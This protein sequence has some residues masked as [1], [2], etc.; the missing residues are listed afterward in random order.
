MAR[1]RSAAAI[2][3]VVIGCASQPEDR[4]TASDLTFHQKPQITLDSPAPGSF[5]S[6]SADGTIEVSGKAKGRSLTINGNTVAVD[7]QGAFR[8]RIPAAP[9]INIVD[10]HL[11]SFWG[12]ELQRAFLYGNFAGAHAALQGGVMVRANALAFDDGDGKPDLNDLSSISL[13]MLKQLDVM[14]F[15]RQLPPFTYDFGAGSVDISVTGVQFA[16]DQTALKL[17]PK[18]VGARVSGSFAQLAVDVHLV[19]H[20]A[21]D[22]DCRGTISVDRA[23]FAG[24]IAAAY[25]AKS[26]AIEAS[27]QK[28]QIALG[29]IQIT[30]DISF[31]GVDQF[32]TWLAN[33]FKGVIEQSIAE[34]IQGSAANHFALTLNQI[35]LPSIF[36]LRPYGL[37]EML[38][39]TSDF[40]SAAFDDAGA[41]I[42]VASNFSWTMA[43]TAPGS[44]IFES[45]PATSFP[46]APFAVSV[47]F[48]A[49]NQAAFAV[50]GQDGL[51]RTV[52]PAE[53][54]KIF[55]LDAVVASPRLPPVLVPT[56][57]GRVQVSLGDV[58]VKSAVHTW[59]FDGPMQATVSA[60]ADVTL[61][62]DP[63]SG[64]LRM[65]LAKR[66][67]IHLDVNDLLGIVPDA[68]LAPLSEVLQ[69]IAPTV[70][71][72]LV[73]PIE[74]PLPRL[75]LSTLIQGSQ[76][77][78]GLGAQA[79]VVIDPAA[80]RVGFSGPLV[81][82]P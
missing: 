34:Q 19:L 50:W 51:V 36:S 37:D 63:Q 75:P 16:K 76:A 21:G 81:Q 62:V 78:L 70:V 46:S 25:S 38:K 18:A 65:T 30:T 2:A 7:S 45:T 79:A 12:G 73:H 72:K 6:P 26:H 42:S 41:K 40:D 74:V 23:G 54:F 49:L 20:L 35:G 10:A 48:D 5:L 57:G 55:K 8:A 27:M 28:P 58:V 80:K 71:E 29:Q 56:S 60:V 68:L 4:L 52:Y 61:D 69:A 9:G 33:T 64:A 39:S 1:I 17:S 11:N 59:I 31:D 32:L 22:H 47:S 43:H 82:Y 53:D 44:I 77:S 24:D 66:P 3:A 67:V 13:A 14:Q 15:V